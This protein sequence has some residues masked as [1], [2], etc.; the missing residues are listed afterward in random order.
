MCE[1][2]IATLEQQNFNMESAALT[3]ENLRNT[4]VTVEAM[5]TTN[6]ELKN[7]YGKVCRWSASYVYD[8]LT[9]RAVLQVDI[10]TI[11]VRFIQSI[12]DPKLD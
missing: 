4:M 12:L 8:I 3:T 5:K 2:Q 1:S 10:D 7:Q 9:C 6:K 11:E